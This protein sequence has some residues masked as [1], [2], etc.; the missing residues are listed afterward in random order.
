MNESMTEVGIEL[1]GQLKKGRRSQRGGRKGGKNA[2]KESL[3]ERRKV[4]KKGRRSQ[5]GARN[6]N[7]IRLLHDSFKCLYNCWEKRGVKERL[8]S[9]NL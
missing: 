4:R 6:H 1:L 2:R 7:H 8:S 5:S 9:S 3:G